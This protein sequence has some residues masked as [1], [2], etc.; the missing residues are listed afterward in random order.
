MKD[1]NSFSINRV[2]INDFFYTLALDPDVK[3]Q[4]FLFSFLY[5]EVEEI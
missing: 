2:C 3:F 4:C 1:E 5:I